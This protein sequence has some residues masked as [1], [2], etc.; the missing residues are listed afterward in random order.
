MGDGRRDASPNHTGGLI[1]EVIQ[2]CEAEALLDTSAF[3]AQAEASPEP[4]ADLSRTAETCLGLDRVCGPATYSSCRECPP[5][6]D[7]EPVGHCSMQ[8]QLVQTQSE[9]LRGPVTD[10]RS[11]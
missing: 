1:Y 2:R 11:Q 8:E 6:T 4:N 3:L 9:R 10:L 5:N 7:P